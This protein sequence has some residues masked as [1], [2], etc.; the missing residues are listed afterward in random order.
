MF[1]EGI[2]PHRRCGQRVDNTSTPALDDDDAWRDKYLGGPFGKYIKGHPDEPSPGGVGPSEEP[3]PPPDDDPE[4][5]KYRMHSTVP[6][7]GQEGD[8][9]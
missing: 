7:W 3:E 1:W 8:T 4:L 6:P 5:D 9:P 2:W